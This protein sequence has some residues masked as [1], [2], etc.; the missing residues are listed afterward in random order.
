MLRRAAL[1]EKKAAKEAAHIAAIEKQREM[2]DEAPVQVHGTP[3]SVEN[4]MAWKLAFE[5][6]NINVHGTTAQRQ[7]T[8]KLTGR[9]LWLQGSLDEADEDSDDD[10]EDKDDEDQDEEEDDVEIDQDDI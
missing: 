6:E 2:D 5:A 1:Q 8:G 7:K 10:E 3:V 4:F 9:Q